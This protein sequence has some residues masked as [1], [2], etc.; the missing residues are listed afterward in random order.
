MVGAGKATTLWSRLTGDEAS[1]FPLPDWLAVILATPGAMAATVFA[2]EIEATPGF[3]LMNVTG[4]PE[5]EIASSAFVVPTVN[6]DKG[7]KVIVWDART[8]S[9]VNVGCVS[10]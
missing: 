6:S 10:V 4:N 3:E 9:P 2:L 5:L 8:M 1:K 7:S